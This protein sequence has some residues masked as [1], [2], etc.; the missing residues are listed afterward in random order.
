MGNNPRL[1]AA[2]SLWAAITVARAARSK[3]TTAVA[4]DSDTPGLVESEPVLDAVT[5]RLEADAGIVGIV[6]D[7]LVFVEP[8]AIAIVESLRPL[9]EN[10]PQTA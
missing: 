9:V 3:D 2:V 5:K 4:E 1:C 6:L 8:S 10:L 7:N